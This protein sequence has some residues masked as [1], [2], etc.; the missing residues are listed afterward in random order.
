MI[1]G[2]PNTIKLK[3]QIQSRLNGEYDKGTQLPKIIHADLCD[4]FW[5]K[6]P[7]V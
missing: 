2:A 5:N 4:I 1:S 6:P 3:V 7:D